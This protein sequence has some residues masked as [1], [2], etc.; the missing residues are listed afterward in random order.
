MA[1]WSSERIVKAIALGV[2]FWALRRL[3][4]LAFGLPAQPPKKRTR[5][6]AVADDDGEKKKAK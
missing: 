5:E 6:P 2:F 4:R 3:L 1:E